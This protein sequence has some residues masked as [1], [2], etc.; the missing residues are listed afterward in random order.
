MILSKVFCCILFIGDVLY[1]FIP[2]EVRS[3]SFQPRTSL[4]RIPPLKQT[5]E[6]IGK[7]EE[8][9]ITDSYTP[10]VKG[11]RVK[12]L[13]CHISYLDSSL[14]NSSG[15]GLFE[16]LNNILA[17]EGEDINVFK[18]VEDLDKDTRFGILSHGTQSDPIFN[19]GNQASLRLFETD[20]ERLCITPSRYS[21][22]PELEPNRD[23]LIKEI[24]QNK[25]GSIINAIRQPISNL[26]VSSPSERK[27]I[28]LEEIL[29]WNLY[30][31][32][33]VRIGEFNFYPFI[34]VCFRKN[35]GCYFKI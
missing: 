26:D 1:A 31:E 35:S 8:G 9:E 15:K 3:K 32:N 25:Y 17:Q 12:N 23:S 22:V 11:G 20:I 4:K 2:S 30:D 34:Y 28:Y 29:V 27:L 16:K 7:G 19:Y 14:K 33:D 10:D 21:T 24:E 13:E 6:T 5:Q 18:S